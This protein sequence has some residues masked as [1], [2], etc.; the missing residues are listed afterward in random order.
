MSGSARLRDCEILKKITSKQAK[1]KRLY[2]GISNA[3]AVILLPWGLLRR[4]RFV[5]STND[6]PRKE[7]FNK[8]DWVFYHTP[9][10]LVPI[11]NGSKEIEV[12]T[13]TAL[14]RRAK[15]DVVV[16]LVEKSVKVSASRDVKII[17]NKF[18]G[19]ATGSIFDMIILSFVHS[20]DDK[21]REEEF[22][23]IDWLLII[24]RM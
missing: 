8:I 15:V 18:I 5:H 13:I 9:H 2:G 16:A 14:P 17:A 11:A 7:E 21:P 12:V 24:L 20:T 6:K 19:D 22:N 3:P 4:K 1:E 10:I 23:K